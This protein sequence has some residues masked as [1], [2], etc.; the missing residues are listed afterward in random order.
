MSDNRRSFDYPSNGK[1]TDEDGNISPAWQLWFSRVHSIAVTGQ[2][3]GT[4]A[5][6]PTEQVWVGRQYMDTTLGKPIYVASVKP[7]VWKDAAG[8]VV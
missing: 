2:Q 6:R 8:T 3:S 5:N 4:T 1:L 7:I